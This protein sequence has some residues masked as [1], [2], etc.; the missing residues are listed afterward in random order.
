MSM[1][2]AIQKRPLLL[3]AIA[4]FAILVAVYSFSID[5]RATRAASI[6]ADEPFY[7]L[8]TQSLIQDGDLDLT[9]QYEKKSYRS[10]FDHPDGLWTQSVPNEEGRLLSPHNPGL[11]LYLIPGFAIRGLLGAQIQMLV[12]A[13]L[14]FSLTFVLA[15]RFTSAT[16][17][18]W[19]VTVVI[20]LCATPFIYSTEI[21]PE[22]P[23]ALLLVA[24]LL[25]LPIHGRAGISWAIAFGLTASLLP[26]LGVK[27]F[28]LGLA[29]GA[30]FL[31]RST[32]PAQGALLATGLSMGFFYIWFHL[33]TFGG[34][35][36]YNVNYVYAGDDTAQ[37]FS[38][39]VD[40]STRYYRLWGIFV[41]RRFGIGHWSPFLLLAI[42][43]IAYA[44][45][46]GTNTRLITALICIQLLIATFVVITMMG[47]WFPGRTMVTV[48]P[49]FSIPIVLVLRQSG[50]WLKALAS[51]LAIYSIAITG[52]LAYAGH[53][54]EVVIAVDPFEMKSPVFR[55]TGAFL[56][57]YRLWNAETYLLNGMWL[58]LLAM[59]VVV[60]LISIKR[61]AAAEPLS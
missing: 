49:L 6:T 46:R 19:L 23:A 56:P 35:T 18:S 54:G 20:A 51:A 50:R 37:L 60:A 57:D 1:R 41:D 5:I 29:V 21:Y 7:L 22:M 10:F 32:K 36:P 4:I 47:W 3:G 43:G 61:R 45:L 40:F 53:K 17:L 24:I 16:R 26:W 38:S 34:L 28:P 8:T 59:A 30:L 11:S 31:L 42:P 33:H 55:V 48:F 52:A 15:Q 13:A 2:S 14:L 12:T 25:M 39:H 58:L 27:Y 44:I 9:N